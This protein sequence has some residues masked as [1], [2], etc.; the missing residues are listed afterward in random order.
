MDQN[1]CPAGTQCTFLD[2]GSKTPAT[3]CTNL[4]SNSQTPAACASNRA[5]RGPGNG[6]NREFTAEKKEK[7]FPKIAIFQHFFRK[8]NSSISRSSA[9]NGQTLAPSGTAQASVASCCPPPF[10]HGGGDQK[11]AVNGAY[12]SPLH[13][14]GGNQKSSSTCSAPLEQEGG[15]VNQFSSACGASPKQG[16]GYQK[17]SSTFGA[18]LQQ[19]GG[20]QK[21]FGAL[22]LP[23]PRGRG[24]K[25][26]LLHPGANQTPDHF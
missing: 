13:P 18:P 6:Q 1:E 14:G 2:P 22:Y 16:G 23:P 19:E 11:I 7:K 3:N 8:K 20:F 25:N 10:R 5:P 17:N 4:A 26:C 21:D 12:L 24:P 15:Y 9:L